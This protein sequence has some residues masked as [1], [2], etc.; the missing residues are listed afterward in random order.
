M[1]GKM[2]AFYRLNKHGRILL[3]ELTQEEELAPMTKEA[4]QI[5]THVK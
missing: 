1:H 4:G 5:V 3:A 2:R